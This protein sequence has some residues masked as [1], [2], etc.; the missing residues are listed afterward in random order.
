CTCCRRTP[1][2]T[3]RGGQST[4]YRGAA[5][6]AALIVGAPVVFST[7]LDTSGGICHGERCSCGCRSGPPSPR[8]WPW[9]SPAASSRAGEAKAGGA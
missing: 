7:M 2:E 4:T 8:L 9:R 3:T 6:R 5:L 1:Q